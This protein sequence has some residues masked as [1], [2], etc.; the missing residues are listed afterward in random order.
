MC[1]SVVVDM[2]V[3]VGVASAFLFVHSVLQLYECSR[4]NWMLRTL[5]LLSMHITV[6]VN[7]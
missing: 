5:W 2:C 6:V 1:K 7:T 3:V 4:C